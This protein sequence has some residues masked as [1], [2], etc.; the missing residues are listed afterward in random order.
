MIFFAASNMAHDNAE[1][2][3]PLAI[4]L[5]RQTQ[6]LA[7]LIPP[8]TPCIAQ[9]QS[10]SNTQEFLSILS[11]LLSNPAYTQIIAT[12]FR[13]IL[14]ELCARW[15]DQGSEDNLVALTLL[16]EVHEELFP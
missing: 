11:Q 12:L 16:I 15:L 4:N 3:N 6:H 7:S 2:F 1:P 14:I 9:L 5:R 13:P 10:A 8:G